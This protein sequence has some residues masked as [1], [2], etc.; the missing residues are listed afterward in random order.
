MSVQT[1]RILHEM[2]FH[3]EAVEPP[4]TPSEHVIRW[5]MVAGFLSILVLEAWLL[6]QVWSFWA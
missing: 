1:D 3:V 6:W 4:L 2:T 5:I